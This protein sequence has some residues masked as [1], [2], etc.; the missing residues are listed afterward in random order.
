VARH[1]E[2]E[3]RALIGCNAL[4]R[5]AVAGRVLESLLLWESGICTLRQVRKSPEGDPGVSHR[6]TR[7][8]GGQAVS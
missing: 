5:L 4:G 8:S 2:S 3:V 1:V 6:R 7:Y